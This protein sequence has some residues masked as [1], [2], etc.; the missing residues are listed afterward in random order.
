VFYGIQ[1]ITYLV[2][3]LV[4]VREYFAEHFGL[5]PV[6]EDA[7]S[8]D[9]SI[10]TTRLRFV[11]PTHPATAEYDQLR[12]AG[13]P[14]VSHIG[15]A[16]DG[17][18]EV[19]ALL[20]AGGVGFAQSQPVQS[21]HDGR[22]VIDLDPTRSCGMNANAEFFGSHGAGAD[23]AMGLRLQLCTADAPEAEVGHAR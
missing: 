8:F 7:T 3:D 14:V 12:R 20:R 21:P 19:V 4:G 22:R 5:E 9:L 6:D 18:G 10:G 2:W 11:R 16:V 23:S 1:H 15:L 13:G 17:L